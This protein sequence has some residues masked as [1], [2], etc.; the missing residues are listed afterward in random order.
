M[1]LLE[2]DPENWVPG[3]SE[4]DHAQTKRQS[5]KPIQSKR[6]ALE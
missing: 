1:L 2:H 3:F 4:K 6:I 5:A